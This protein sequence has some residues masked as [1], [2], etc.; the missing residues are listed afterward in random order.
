MKIGIIS[1]EVHAKPHAQQLI[2]AGHEVIM[3]GGSPASLPKTLD[4]IVCRTVSCSHAASALAT[5]ARR[6]GRKVLFMDSVS[7]ITTEVEALVSLKE[8]ESEETGPVHGVTHRAYNDARKGYWYIKTG[9]KWRTHVGST[10]SRAE[11]VARV[12]QLDFAALTTTPPEPTPEVLPAL[13]IEASLPEV[14]PLE[15]ALGEPEPEPEPETTIY[16][17]LKTALEL[18]AGEMSK[19]GLSIFEFKDLGVTIRLSAMHAT[20]PSGSAC[21]T[22]GRSTTRLADVTC[23]RCKATS[24][25]TTAQWVLANVRL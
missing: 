22:V 17:D 3:L 9:P 2:A 24:F 1:K 12:E 5:K 19:L 7:S 18:A 20:G 15:S 4:V 8:P 11:A 23:D 10:R 14:K 6:E 21:G 16:D 25:Y 13:K